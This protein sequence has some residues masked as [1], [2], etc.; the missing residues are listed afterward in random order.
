MDVLAESLQTSQVDT[1]L[2]VL[3]VVFGLFLAYHGYNKFASGISG[4]EGWFRSIGF[5]WPGLQARL[6]GTT[7]IGAGVLFALGLVTPLAAAAI[8]AVMIVAI[9]VAH[10][11]VGFFVFKPGQGWEYCASIAVVAWAVAAA[12]PG[13]FSLDRA[14]SLDDTF[15]AD[16][17]WGAVVAAVVGVGGAV[18]QLAL[19]YRPGPSS[20]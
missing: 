20:T 18:T 10:W 19:C 2:V 12:G 13:R 11:K 9:V 8:I 15:L 4:T 6:A 16:G 7:E 1:A 17:W 14:V 3:R 5:R